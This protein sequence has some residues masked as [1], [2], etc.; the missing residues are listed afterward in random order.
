[1]IYLSTIKIIV[2]ILALM[3]M[4]TVTMNYAL[5]NRDNKFIYSIAQ[6]TIVPV[7]FVNI[8]ILTIMLFC[9]VFTDGYVLM[10]AAFSACIVLMM[11]L[12]CLVFVATI[13]ENFSVAMM[14]R[15]KEVKS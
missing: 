15:K 2:M 4:A 9:P 5:L 1:M 6:Y 3:F 12:L 8:I 11:V 13:A 14:N 10:T 7:C